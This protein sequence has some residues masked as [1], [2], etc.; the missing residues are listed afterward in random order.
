MKDLLHGQDMIVGNLLFVTQN[1]V[2]CLCVH[3]ST[4]LIT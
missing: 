3:V 2:V 4:Y 1:N